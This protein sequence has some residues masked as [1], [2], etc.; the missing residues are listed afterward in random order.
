VRVPIAVQVQL[1]RI[2][3]AANGLAAAALYVRAVISG[4]YA[5]AI[6]ESSR[7]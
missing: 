4:S 2:E 6:P 5:F 1:A 7:S 3:N